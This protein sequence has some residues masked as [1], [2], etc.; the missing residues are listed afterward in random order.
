MEKRRVGVLSLAGALAGLAA[1]AEA[2]QEPMGVISAQLT[3]KPRRGAWRVESIGS[4][5]RQARRQ[6]ERDYLAETGRRLS[7]RQFVRMR[8]RMRRQLKAQ[9]RAAAAAK[10]GEVG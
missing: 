7:S 10:A 4:E 3:G 1:S 6:L 5:R 8:K 2:V 9:D